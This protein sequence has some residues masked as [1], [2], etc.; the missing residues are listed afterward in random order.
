MVSHAKIY[1][2]I[3]CDENGAIDR[4]LPCTQCGYE[5]RGCRPDDTCPECGQSIRSSA[6]GGEQRNSWYQRYFGTIIVYAIFLVFITTTSHSN[7]YFAFALLLLIAT[8]IFL[9][10]VSRYKRH[11]LGDDLYHAIL[12]TLPVIFMWVCAISVL[13][14][15]FM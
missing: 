13:A 3:K 11:R 14:R 8:P 4:T 7:P 15:D 12:V 6:V 2:T 9:V 10:K 5:L 1:G